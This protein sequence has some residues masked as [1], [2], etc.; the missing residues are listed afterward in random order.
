MAVQIG[1]SDINS[2][3]FINKCG[4]NIAGADG[5]AE[6]YECQDDVMRTGGRRRIISILG[7]ANCDAIRIQLVF[8][9]Q[10]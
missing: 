5:K 4:V 2:L 8:R 6:T 10:S 9:I 3:V 1:A 7:L